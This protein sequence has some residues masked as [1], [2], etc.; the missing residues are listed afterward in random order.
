MHSHAI[1]SFKEKIKLSTRQ[2][3]IIIG[4]ILGDGC[5]VSQSQKR[6]Y[7]LQIEHSLKQKK[8]V[9]WLYQELKTLIRTPPKMKRQYVRGKVYYKYW[10]N[11]LS[12]EELQ[13]YG[14][15]FLNRFVIG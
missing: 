11:T 5:L 3:E 2:R 6:T 8:Y 14:Q 12:I 10:F 13:F 7:R 1:E 9:I 15:Q 4:K